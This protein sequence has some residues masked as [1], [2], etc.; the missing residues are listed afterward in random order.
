MIDLDTGQSNT[1]IDGFEYHLVAP[2][3][4]NEFNS[5]SDTV[6]VFFAVCY[7]EQVRI[8][9]QD[10]TPMYVLSKFGPYRYHGMQHDPNLAQ[11]FRN[12]VNMFMQTYPNFTVADN[13]VLVM[14]KDSDGSI[15]YYKGIII[16]GG[17]LFGFGF[18]IGLAVLTV[19]LL[20][21]KFYP[22]HPMEKQPQ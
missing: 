22:E 9:E 17:V 7:V 4:T 12:A 1:V 10:V 3:V 5:S 18:V 6:A 19:S 8:R 21:F 20:I 15:S 2:L 14:N 11:Q 13:A 16:A